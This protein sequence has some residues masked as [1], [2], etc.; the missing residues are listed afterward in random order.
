[1]VASLTD[2]ELM[3]WWVA[4]G[5]PDDP[6]DPD[7]LV[8]REMPAWLLDAPPV[9]EEPVCDCGCGVPTAVLEASAAA[10]EAPAVAEPVWWAVPG[11]WGEVPVQV[12][13]S[14]GEDVTA[15]AVIVARLAAVDP[16]LL[17]AG[18]ALGEAEALAQVQH[19]L[20]VL[21]LARTQDVTDRKLFE[22]LGYRS[23]TAWQ[24]HTAPDAPSSDRAL[25]G[26]LPD[27]PHLQR[28]L[29]ERRVCFAAAS[30]VK[31]ALGKVR[32]FLDRP[33]GLIDGQPGGP[34]IEAVLGNVLDLVCRDR[35]GLEHDPDVDPQQAAFLA[36]LEAQLVAIQFSAAGQREQVE[37]ALVLLAEHV[38]VSA[39]TAALEDVVLQILPT[40]LEDAEKAAQDR[41]DL[42]LTPNSDGTWQLSATL[43]P[44]VGEQ[45]HT[46]LAAEA[47]RDP[48][49]PLDT[50]TREQARAAAAEH[51]GADPWAAAQDRPAWEDRALREHGA[52][53]DPDQ[54]TL[55]P[56]TRSKRL[57]DAFGRLLTRYLAHGLGGVSGK[58]PVQVTVTTSHRTITGA[59]GAPPARGGSGRPLA[60]SLLRRWWCDAHVT[61]LLMS[62]G[63]KPLG[64]VHTARTITG[65]ELKAVRAQYGNRCA[66]LDCCPGT[67]D[68][69]VPLVPHH[70]RRHAVFG[71][72]S[73]EETLLVC[74]RLH[75]DLHVGK[76]TLRLR[77]GR[78]I[79]EDGYLEEI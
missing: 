74:D 58:I 47:R 73:I 5:L 72:T 54:Q 57:H 35:F 78:L 44:E 22:H 9:D 31:T 13:P 66:G 19:R 62:H 39:L 48:A 20:R 29:S 3:P 77:D 43:T 17:P 38:T 61:T 59:P 18:Q 11:V 37:R 67:P 15:V 16:A 53:F 21:Q 12:T 25:A 55:V 68:P 33:D 8:V 6:A 28:A 46:A 65:T 7:D 52:S 79:T 14:V 60:R 49:N 27:L 10:V 76:R 26:K 34:V 2:E 40:A 23:S 41:R 24:R 42:S 1:V 36:A 51:A 64:V 45:L 70:V 30:K 75:A 4:A 56:R 69:L 50:H 32:Q 71:Q 63:W